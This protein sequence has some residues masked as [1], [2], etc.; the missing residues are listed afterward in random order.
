MRPMTFKIPFVASTGIWMG[1]LA[2]PLLPRGRIDS[3]ASDRHKTIVSFA[4]DTAKR[5][6]QY[7]L[8]DGG[9]SI[10][11]QLDSERSGLFRVT[12]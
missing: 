1:L 5:T 8:R 11:L 9:T 10:P 7:A 3:G 2:Q 12:S 4:L 6:F